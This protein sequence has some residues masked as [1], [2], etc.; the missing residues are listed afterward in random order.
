MENEENSGSIV[1]IEEAK[2][3]QLSTVHVDI[4]YQSVGFSINTC[5]ITESTT[6]GLMS[7]VTN[8]SHNPKPCTKKTDQL[9]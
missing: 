8:S 9:Y 1:N 3:K 4:S 5:Y 2:V 7:K 6:T